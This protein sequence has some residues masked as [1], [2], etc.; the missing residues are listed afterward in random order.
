MRGILSLQLALK[1]FP[2]EQPSDDFAHELIDEG[3]LSRESG[4]HARNCV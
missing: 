2:P 4:A 3:R 1:G